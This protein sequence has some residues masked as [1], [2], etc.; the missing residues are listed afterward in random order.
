MSVASSGA[1]MYEYLDMARLYAASLEARA[2]GGREKDGD[3]GAQFQV[4]SLFALLHHTAT[5]D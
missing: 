3:K 4:A 2:E 1:V 5:D